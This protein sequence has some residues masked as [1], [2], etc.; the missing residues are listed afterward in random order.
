MDEKRNGE[1]NFSSIF[2]SSKFEENR[3]VVKKKNIFFSFSAATTHL[4]YIVDSSKRNV[5]CTIF[6][7]NIMIIVVPFPAIFCI[8]L[9]ARHFELIH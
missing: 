6:S 5:G 8:L 1:K 7:L 4:I 2:F 3:P 9:H